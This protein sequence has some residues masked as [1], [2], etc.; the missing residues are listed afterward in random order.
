M[1]QGDL[2]EGPWQKIQVLPLTRY[3]TVAYCFNG[4]ARGNY[5]YMTSDILRSIIIIGIKDH[6]YL[7][8]NNI[9]FD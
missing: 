8:F 1:Q 7:V 4:T 3:S 6:E 5:V 2:H 9:P